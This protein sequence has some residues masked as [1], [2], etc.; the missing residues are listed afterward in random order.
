MRRYAVVGGSGAGKS[1]VCR[2]L[3]RRGGVHL[4]VDRLGHTVLRRARLRRE[5]S[6]RFGAAILGPD[7]GIDRRALGRV[8]F[9]DAAK[10]SALN[11][12][13]HPHIGALLRRRLESL[14]RRRVRFVV[15]DA[16]LFL[17]V[18][19]GVP[20]DAVIAV[21]AR[22]AL[23]RT[24]LRQRSGLGAAEVEARLRS[25]RRLGV[26]TRHADFR[27][28][29]SGSLELV[30]RRVEALWRALCRRKRR[31]RGGSGWKRRSPQTSC[32]SA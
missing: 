1:T 29:T 27:L 18:D 32:K 30:E 20:V 15:I 31:K 8:V 12:L 19:L 10:R 13:V 22:R 4:D 28:D 16:A 11:A 5:L 9:A 23:R 24:R 3:A 6:A 26:W 2:L 17:D 7:G 14:E 21:T 25:Q